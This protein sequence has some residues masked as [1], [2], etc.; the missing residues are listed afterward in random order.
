[1]SD[2]S[3]EKIQRVIE[4][5]REDNIKFIRL[6]FVDINGTVKNI[7]IPFIAEDMEELF[8]EGML[9]DGSSIEG[10]VGIN[11]SDL[12]LKPDINTYS[13][14]SWRPEESAT[15]RF[16]C[17]VWTPERKPFVGDPRSVLR[18]SISKL[19]KMGLQYNIG[20]EPEFFIVDIDENGNPMPYDDAAYF[21]VEPLDKGPDFR[22]EL[23]LNLEELDFEIEASHHEVAPG[24]NELA[25][26]F[27]DAL[28]TADAVI[29]FKQAIKAIVD[30]M[31][32]FDQMDYR[33][34]FMPKPFFGVNGSGMHCHQSVF[35]GDRNLFSNPNSETGLSK[36]ALHF[37]GGLLAHAPAITAITNPIVN[38]YKRLVPGYEAPVY[39]AYGLKNRS[40]LIRVP[41]ARGKATRIE[42]RSPDP[43]CNPY[44]A[45]A[46]ML[47]AGVD[48]IVNKIDPGEPCEVNLYEATEKDLE[49]LGI[50]VLPTSLWEAYHA[51]E[52]DELILN[53]L[54]DH[55]SQKFL[56]LKYNEW[57]EYRVQVFGYEQR[58][59]L[60][61]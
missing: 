54:G 38:S 27:R 31:A 5:M 29:T 26:K 35:K 51:L 49:E 50:S 1:M 34:T 59:Y 12:V 24:Q 36:D 40:T 32:T 11:E 10:F 30:N 56:E 14:L 61:I 28:T 4:Q 9:F 33:V 16:I 6:Q 19:E 7:V 46:V 44:L 52:E 13:R 23:S 48:G 39:M 3:E 18:K 2:I 20:P 21:D 17:D 57:D 58:K 8:Q 41:A 15:C 53:A 60:D 22:R 47:E 43:A 55:V 45:F 25:F 42:Y 37:M